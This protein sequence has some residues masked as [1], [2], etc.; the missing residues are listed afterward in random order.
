MKKTLSI[1]VCALASITIQAQ[2]QSNY[3]LY[4]S[5]GTSG[6]LDAA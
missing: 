1:A 6:G 4:V 3:S 2:A 5:E